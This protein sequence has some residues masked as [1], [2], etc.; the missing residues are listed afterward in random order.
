MADR[1]RDR[2]R[3]RD[4]DLAWEEISVEHVVQDQ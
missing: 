3:D 1:G 4:K 2:D